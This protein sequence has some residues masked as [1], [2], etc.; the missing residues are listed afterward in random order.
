[1]SKV[2]AL[3]NDWQPRILSV[4][5]IVTA[6]TLLEF[7]L[8]KWFDFPPARTWAPPELLSQAGITGS[9]EL[10]GGLLLTLGL[11]TRPVAFLLSGEMAFAYWIAHFPRNPFPISNFGIPALLFCFIFFYVFVA[12][13]GAWSIDNALKRRAA[14]G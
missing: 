11:F 8:Q 13:G 3:Q 2:Q 9:I 7:G 5:R 12:G 14:A 4:L 10:V 6:L 1:M